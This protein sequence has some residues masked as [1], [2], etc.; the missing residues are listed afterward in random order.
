MDKK[1]ILK[2]LLELFEIKE[3]KYGFDSQDAAI[4]WSNKVAPLLKLVDPQYYINFVQNSHK[5]NLNLSSYSLIPALNIMKSQIEMAIEELKIR[6]AMEEGL[7]DE[8]YFSENSFL[9]IQKNIARIIRQSKTMLRICDG[10]MDEKIIEEIT[11]VN[12]QEIRLLT[13]KQKGIFHQRLDAARKQFPSKHIEVRESDK[14]HDRYY[15][16][17]EDQVWSLGASYNQAG[18]KATLLSKIKHGT[19][20]NKI[21]SDFEKWWLSS[22]PI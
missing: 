14:F 3:L 9:D 7:P 15:I 4:S 18:Q 2:K 20:K 1:P 17:D 16:I 5:L 11:E 13:S 22:T 19:E 6:I 8:M 12:V 21:I 10:Y